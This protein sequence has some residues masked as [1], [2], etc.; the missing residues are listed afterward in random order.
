MFGIGM[1]PSTQE[2]NE[3]GALSD[4][5]NFATSSGESAITSANNF[6]SSILSGDPTQIS[7]VLGPQLSAIN[8][9]GQ[10]KLKTTSEFGNRSGGNNAFNQ[11]TGDKT[12]AT[13]NDLISSLTSTAASALGA[14]GSGLLSAG[15]TGHEG[16]FIEANTIQSQHAAQMSDLFNSIAKLASSFG[17]NPIANDIGD[18]GTALSN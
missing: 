16:A 2:K 8:K 10:Q 4:L 17:G 18:I 14:S 15:I 5:S 1:G 3:F 6:W 7:K 9:Q 12:R 13:A 11:E